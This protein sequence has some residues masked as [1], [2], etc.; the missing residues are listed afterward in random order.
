MNRIVRLVCGVILLAMETWMMPAVAQRVKFDHYKEFKKMLRD[1]KKGDAGNLIKT[2]FDEKK[3]KPEVKEEERDSLEYF[4]L[5]GWLSEYDFEKENMKMYL[6]TQADTVKYYMS[7]YDTFSFFSRCYDRLKDVEKYGKPMISTMERLKGNLG[8]GGNYFILKSDFARSLNLYGLYLTLLHQKIL[9]CADS[10]RC[11]MYY[12]VVLSAD[13]MEDYAQVAQWAQKA[14]QQGCTS[15]EMDMM[16]CNALHRISDEETWLRAVK[17]SIAR[18]PLQFYFYG[19]IIDY[20]IQNNRN[21]K[22]MTYAYE[23]VEKDSLSYLNCFVKGYVHQRTGDDRDAILWLKRSLKQNP[24]FIPSL[25][26]LGFSYIRLAE[27]RAASIRRVR[28][29]DEEKAEISSYYEKARQYLER[30]RELDPQKKE[31]W[32]YGLYKV[33]YNLNEGEKLEMLEQQMEE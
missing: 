33:Y 15:E 7:L 22:A 19:L 28:L 3:K 25:S 29:S 4:Y 31:N 9:T 10:V 16:W 26:A 11:Q 8:R 14:L 27:N 21:D 1:D 6:G 13:K 30:C 18:N 2:L 24:D 23:L 17:E 12:N 5:K 32:I 20:Y